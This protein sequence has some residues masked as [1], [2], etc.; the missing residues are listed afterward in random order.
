MYLPTPSSYNFQPINECSGSGPKLVN[1]LQ[2]TNEHAWARSP[3]T[4]RAQRQNR[5]RWLRGLGEEGEPVPSKMRPQKAYRQWPVFP[6][7]R[8]TLLT[9][10]WDKTLRPDGG[11]TAYA[12]HALPSGALRAVWV[13]VG[14][15][16]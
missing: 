11:F 5:L 4:A 12:Q 8:R 15:A 14:V 1:R 16:D 10:V 6:G 9:L 13:Q 7:N 2:G 3:I